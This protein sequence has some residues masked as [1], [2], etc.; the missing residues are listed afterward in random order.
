MHFSVLAC[1]DLVPSSLLVSFLPKKLSR[2]VW[3]SRLFDVVFR[4]V[5]LSLPAVAFKSHAHAPTEFLCGHSPMR[6]L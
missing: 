3:D 1:L 2:V 5:F 6:M 4:A